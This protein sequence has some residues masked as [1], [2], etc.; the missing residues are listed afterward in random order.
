MTSSTHEGAVH[1]HR[2][3]RADD[4][5]T[6]DCAKPSSHWVQAGILAASL[7]RALEPEARRFGT[8]VTGHRTG[9]RLHMR[10]EGCAIYRQMTRL[11][12]I[13]VTEY[14]TCYH[15]SETS[16]TKQ[17]QADQRRAPGPLDQSPDAPNIPCVKDLRPQTPSGFGPETGSRFL[18]SRSSKHRPA[19]R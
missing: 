13:R 18:P 3:G 12:W 6:S 11:A 10:S 16:Q 14:L 9:L 15:G 2:K 19:R 8:G 4:L 5:C 7:L 17:P 1:F